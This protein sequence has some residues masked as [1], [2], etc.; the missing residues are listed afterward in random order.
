M[1][2]RNFY[3]NFA[4]SKRV[5]EMDPGSNTRKKVS[6]S[7]MRKSKKIN[8]KAESVSKSLIHGRKRNVIL[9]SRID[10]DA[11]KSFLAIINDHAKSSLE[12]S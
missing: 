6:N 4:D 3:L 7:S 12:W 1:L 9:E 10:F 5:H 8:I 2:N 11:S